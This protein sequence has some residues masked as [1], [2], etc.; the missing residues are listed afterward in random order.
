LE[1][2]IA[3]ITSEPAK[4]VGMHDRG[5]VAEGRIADINLI[6]ADELRLHAPRVRYDLPAGGRRLTQGASGYRMTMKRGVVIYRDG[7]P[8]GALPGRVVRSGEFAAA[9]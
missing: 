8:T 5:L 7:E 4:L 2:A 9:A 6:D 1:K 3:A